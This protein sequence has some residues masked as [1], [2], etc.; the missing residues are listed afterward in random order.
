MKA[1][2]IFLGHRHLAF[3]PWSYAF[4]YEVELSD[5]RLRC[6]SGQATADHPLS[7][8]DLQ[9]GVLTY[10]AGQNDVLASDMVVRLFHYSVLEPLS[11][12]IVPLSKKAVRGDS[13]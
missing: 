8:V 6:S 2:M 5:G 10:L 12:G 7:E 3:T 1:D 11:V 13:R 4:T 9:I